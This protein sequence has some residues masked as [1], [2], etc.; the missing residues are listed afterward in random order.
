MPTGW[1]EE[2]KDEERAVQDKGAGPSG[3]RFLKTSHPVRWAASGAVVRSRAPY[4]TFSPRELRARSS[5]N[6][7][8]LIWISDEWQLLGVRPHTQ[9][10]A[11]L[12]RT[13]GL[14]G[15]R[16]QASPPTPPLDPALHQYSRWHNNQRSRMFIND[17]HYIPASGGQPDNSRTPLLYSLQQLKPTLQVKKWGLSS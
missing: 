6:N 17:R 1:P 2:N 14:C 8:L 12:Q 3:G 10:T 4:S 9:T 15:L 11:P 5:P 7:N 16:E 13:E